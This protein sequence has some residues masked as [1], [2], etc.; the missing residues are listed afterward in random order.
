MEDTKLDEIEQCLG[1]H[2]RVQIMYVVDG[3][4]A[5]LEAEDGYAGIDIKRY[6]KTIFDALLDLDVNLT[7]QQ[8]GWRRRSKS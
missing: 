8:V 7:N 3:Y 1:L 5:E 2:E 4:Q 6:G